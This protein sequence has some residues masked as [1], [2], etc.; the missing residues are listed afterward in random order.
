M[1]SN[2]T[3]RV[4]AILLHLHRIILQLSTGVISMRTTFSIRKQYDAF[5]LKLWKI[6]PKI[7]WLK[8]TDLW[9]IISLYILS[10]IIGILYTGY[11]TSST[12]GFNYY[13]FYLL[14]IFQSIQGLISLTVE[15]SLIRYIRFQFSAITDELLEH[16]SSGK[17]QNSNRLNVIEIEMKK[18]NRSRNIK[19]LIFCH[20]KVCNLVDNF[21]SIFGI[22][23]LLSL[24]LCFIDILIHAELFS[25]H[26]F[27]AP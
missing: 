25:A 5:L 3:E 1:E 21:N 27:R 14:G 10:V 12:Q 13:A 17:K 23:L 15:I 22:H 7:S 26:V 8:S 6:N 20:D 2:K 9:R 16:Q 19:E 4:W 18:T 11:V 24:F